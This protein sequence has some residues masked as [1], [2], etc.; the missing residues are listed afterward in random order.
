M[1]I[2]HLYEIS[3][4]LLSRFVSHLSVNPLR[5]YYDL[6]RTNLQ[7][8]MPT[9]TTAAEVFALIRRAPKGL[10]SQAVSLGESLFIPIRT[11]PQHKAVGHIASDT[12]RALGKST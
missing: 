10:Y 6:Y 8:S 5:T 7:R 2:P 1:E 3:L 9:V 4:K 12:T 11:N